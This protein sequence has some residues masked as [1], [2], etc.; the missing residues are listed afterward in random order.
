MIKISHPASVKSLYFNLPVLTV[1]LVKEPKC[2]HVQI[3]LLT[4]LK[5]HVS[6]LFFTTF[7]ITIELSQVFF[8]LTICL[9]KSLLWSFEVPV[10]AICVVFYWLI[11]CPFILRVFTPLFPFLR[12]DT[13]GVWRF[14]F[15]VRLINAHSLPA[16]YHSFPCGVLIDRLRLSLHSKRQKAS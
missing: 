16:P 9:F 3:C 14:V 15:S 7:Y 13:C 1:F 2:I 12:V 5:S 8:F 11:I 6:S 4:S 10:F